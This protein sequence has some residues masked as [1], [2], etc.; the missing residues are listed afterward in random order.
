M[1][2]RAVQ[3]MARVNANLPFPSYQEQ[4]WVHSGQRSSAPTVTYRSRTLRIPRMDRYVRHFTREKILS[5][6]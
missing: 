6:R 5:K 4:S 3:H 1:V 2:A